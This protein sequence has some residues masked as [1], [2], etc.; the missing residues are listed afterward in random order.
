[1]WNKYLSDPLFGRQLNIIIAM[2]AN[3]ALL[4]AG[5]LAKYLVVDSSERY[6]KA[7]IIIRKFG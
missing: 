3:E 2:L 5:L 4:Y 7:L 6:T 1:M